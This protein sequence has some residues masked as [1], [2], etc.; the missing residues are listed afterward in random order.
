MIGLIAIATLIIIGMIY[1][2]ITNWTICRK[3]GSRMDMKVDPETGYN[4]YTCRKCG[5][6]V[7]I[8]G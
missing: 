7:T 4:V 5:R 8:I 3:C 2:L 1:V 6:R